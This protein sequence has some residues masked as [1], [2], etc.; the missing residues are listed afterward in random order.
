MAAV[1]LDSY[2]ERGLAAVHEVVARLIGPRI[3][4]ALDAAAVFDF[5]TELQ[6]W[7]QKRYK[8]PVH[9][10]IV[11]E[12]GPDHE[13]TFESAVLLRDQELAR[14]QGRS[15]K[16]AEQAAARIALMALRTEPDGPAAK[17]ARP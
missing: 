7:A 14:G 6:E 2:G 17:G 3:E 5:K 16:Q 8:E 10:R 9:Y 15:K 11:S 4:Q 12:G 13:K 1:Y